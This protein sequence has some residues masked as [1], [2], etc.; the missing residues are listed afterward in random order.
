MK[1]LIFGITG[2]LGH[3]VFKKLKEDFE[4]YGS[5]RQDKKDLMQEFPRFINESDKI[6][7]NIDAFYLEAIE[8][9]FVFSKPELVINCI[10]IIKQLKEANDPIL[11]ISINALLPHLLAKRCQERGIK[12]I[13]ISTDCV[14]SGK[15]GM[16][17][18]TDIPDAEDLYGRSKCLGEVAGD[19]CLTIRTSLIGRQLRGS[20]SLLEWFLAQKGQVKGFRKAVFSGLTTAAFSSILGEIIRRHKD[21]CGIYHVAGEPISKYDL[22]LRLKE[23]YQ[24]NIDILP[25]EMVKVDR[26]LNP[27]KFRQATSIGIPNWDEMME[28]LA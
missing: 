19:N 27:Q 13:Q 17:A 15:K 11:S 5:V 8:K 22:L 23:V 12:F 28:G 21:L 2:M 26:S 9:A 3:A 10:G 16:Y 14:F 18:E 7:D 24:K 20:S 1:I 25:D 4:V 6:I